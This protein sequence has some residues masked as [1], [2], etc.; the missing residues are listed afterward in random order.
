MAQVVYLS[1]PTTS[2]WDS[3][4]FLLS[5]SRLMGLDQLLAPAWNTA[6]ACGFWRKLHSQPK[7][8]LPVPWETTHSHYIVK[9]HAHTHGLIRWLGPT[10]TSSHQWLCLVRGEYGERVGVRE[11]EKC[12]TQRAKRILIIAKN[13]TVKIFPSVFWLNSVGFKF[14][15]A[16]SNS[17]FHSSLFF[18]KPGCFLS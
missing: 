12:K 15:K 13:G 18:F 7:F 11:N 17:I 10:C 5:L 9:Y 6:R 8:P 2:S 3:R 4:P 1:I 16:E 14:T